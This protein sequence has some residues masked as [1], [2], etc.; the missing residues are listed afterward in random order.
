MKHTFVLL[1]NAYGTE[2]MR[3]VWTEE[4]MVQKWLD[5]EVAITKAKAE[6]GI[7]TWEQAN[8][9]IEKSSV[10]YLTPQMIAEV[11]AGAAHLIVS[12][13]KAFA[14]MC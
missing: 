5:M 6:V 4:N 8:G 7:I 2:E 10:K 1:K 11:K 13:I 9:I 3:K 14:K 12:F